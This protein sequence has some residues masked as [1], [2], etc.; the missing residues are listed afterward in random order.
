M[1]ITSEQKDFILRNRGMI[2]QI[3]TERMNDYF[4][5]VVDEPNSQRK[6]VLSML[7]K[8]FRSALQMIENLGKQKE[9]KKPEEDFT[10]V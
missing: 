6:E 8:E 9:V 7:V 3:L 4:N 2:Q 1:K 5:Q 10:G